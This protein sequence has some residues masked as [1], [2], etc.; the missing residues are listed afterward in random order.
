MVVEN[1]VA[2]TACLYYSMT[3]FSSEEVHHLIQISKKHKTL[4]SRQAFNMQ[5]KILI[6][7]NTKSNSNALSL[8][9]F[10]DNYVAD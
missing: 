2:Q 10:A 4:F 8:L 1:P 9:L 5:Y 3:I 6:H 7:C